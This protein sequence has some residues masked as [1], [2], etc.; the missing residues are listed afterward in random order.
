MS[1]QLASNSAHPATSRVPLGFTEY[2]PVLAT[3]SNPMRAT[4]LLI[5]DSF[6]PLILRESVWQYST[7]NFKEVWG[8]LLATSRRISPTDLSWHPNA[9]ILR[10]REKI[11]N[12]YY[13]NLLT[14]VESCMKSDECKYS[15]GA[16]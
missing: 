13:L 8:F 12:P 1:T 7:L 6:T 11:Q 9:H 16:S 4:P 10:F 3:A 15:S 14:I 5:R 2:I